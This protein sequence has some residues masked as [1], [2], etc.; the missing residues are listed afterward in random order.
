MVFF[1]VVTWFTIQAQSDGLRK[2][3]L[4]KRM[5][6]VFED[7]G[8]Q[9]ELP[10][11]VSSESSSKKDVLIMLHPTGQGEQAEQGYCVKI[12]VRRLSK[13]ELDSN[14]RMA[15]HPLTDDFNKWYTTNHPSLDIRKAPKVWRIRK[16]VPTPGGL[17]LFIDGQVTVTK[18]VDAD[19][20]ETRR[21]VE[22]IKPLR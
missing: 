8:V 11:A 14:G 12:H 10:D 22:S 9:M 15:A 3:P 4:E 1:G 20:T 2:T 18:S 17:S 7:A 13:A 21:I 19:L 6:K 5:T 16:D